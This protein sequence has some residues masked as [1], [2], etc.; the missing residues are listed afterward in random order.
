MNIIES[1]IKNKQNIISEHQAK[2][3]L[4]SYNIPVVREDLAKSPEEAIN[5]AEEIGY[6]VVLKGFSSILTHKSEYGVIELNLKNEDEVKEGWQKIYNAKIK[7]D[8]VLVQEQIKGEV[9]L[10]V[11]LK[12][13]ITF[14]LCVVFG[15]GGI[16]TEV[17]KDISIRVI[18]IDK[19]DA[20][21]MIKEIK[22]YKILEGYRGKRGVDIDKLCEILVNVGKIAQDFPQIK[23]LDINPLIVQDGIPIAVDALI[24]LDI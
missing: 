10:I 13:D 20:K 11:G 6:P 8:G 9:E 5:V 7:L 4:S 3:F 12:K 18:P 1:T 2:K 22:G 24:I 17:L 23:E 15:L 16:F 14:G 21:E 19:I